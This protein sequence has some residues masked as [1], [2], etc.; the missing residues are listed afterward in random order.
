M[1][2]SGLFAARCRITFITSIPTLYEMQ[3]TEINICGSLTE[4]KLE[5]LPLQTEIQFERTL[6]LIRGIWNSFKTSLK[7]KRNVCVV[8]TLF[9]SAE[10]MMEMAS[11]PPYREIEYSALRLMTHVHSSVLP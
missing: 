1:E 2:G 4:E 5:H 10:T 7:L 6:P 8:A 9:A 3:R 11:S